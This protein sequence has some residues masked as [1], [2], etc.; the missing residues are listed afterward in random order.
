MRT[1]KRTFRGGAPAPSAAL[2]ARENLLHHAPRNLPLA[3][4]DEGRTVVAETFHLGIEMGA[5]DNGETRSRCAIAPRMNAM[6][7]PATRVVISGVP[8]I[9]SHLQLSVPSA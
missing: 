8:C 3:H 7:R 6:P 2:T 4:N 5:G 9:A 1:D